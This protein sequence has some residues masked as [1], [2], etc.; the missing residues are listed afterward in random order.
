MPFANCIARLVPVVRDNQAPNTYKYKWQKRD[1][2]GWEGTNHLVFCPYVLVGDY[3]RQ[4]PQEFG[5]LCEDVYSVVLS[6]RPDC[7][8]FLYIESGCGYNCAHDKR[9]LVGEMAARI[10]CLLGRG[11]SLE[12]I[13]DIMNAEMVNFVTGDTLRVR[14]YGPVENLE[15]EV[16]DFDLSGVSIRRLSDGDLFQSVNAPGFGV[17]SP[18]PGFIWE[19]FYF[20][21]A[22]VRYSLVKAFDNPQNFDDVLKPIWERLEIC[23]SLFGE[24][25]VKIYQRWT[26]CDVFFPRMWGASLGNGPRHMRAYSMKPGVREDFISVYNKSWGPCEKAFSFAAKRLSYAEGRFDAYDSI[27]DA[28]VGMESVLLAAI[29]GSDRGELGYRFALNYATFFLDYDSRFAAFGLAKALYNARSAIVHGDEKRLR[30]KNFKEINP[31]DPTASGC[32]LVAKR[33][34]RQLLLELLFTQRIDVTKPD[35]WHRRVL[36]GNGA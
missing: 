3:E 11:E 23:M 19:Y 14:F 16:G 15:G 31:N 30:T 1:I 28:V 12:R 8:G 13:I 17:G 7:S 34:L 4:F 20:V 32:A 22:S 35:E 33:V 25:P 5:Q 27:V 6:L 9:I 26:D 18:R 24:G 2:G 21:E 10:A 29:D 36:S